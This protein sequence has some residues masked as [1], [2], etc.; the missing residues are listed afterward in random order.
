MRNRLNN[1]DREFDTDDRSDSDDFNDD[2]DDEEGA[3]DE[4]DSYFDCPHCGKTILE[5]SD[6]CPSCDTWITQDEQ[7][8]QKPYLWFYITV[9]ICLAIVLKMIL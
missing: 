6:Y 2:Y 4:S 3:Y 7:T 5:G 9:G 8:K 1:D